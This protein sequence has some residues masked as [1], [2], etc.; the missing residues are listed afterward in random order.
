MQAGSATA[1]AR[2]VVSRAG[3]DTFA[4]AASIARVRKTAPRQRPKR[5]QPEHRGPGCWGEL[6]GPCRI[7]TYDQRIKS[8]LLY[9][10]S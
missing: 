1:V 10:L 3:D 2:S 4:V 8:P 5:K 9:Q 6:G 7:R